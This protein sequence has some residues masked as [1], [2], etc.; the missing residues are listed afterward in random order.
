[1]SLPTPTTTFE[2]LNPALAE[3]SPYLPF[4]GEFPIRLDANE[5]PP[6]L[7]SAARERLAEVARTT[8]LERYPDATQDALRTVLAAR[9]GRSKTEILV[10]DGSDE[11]IALLLTAVNRS[12]RSGAPP[13]LLSTSPTF[14][15]YRLSAKIRG[16]QVIEVPL[17]ADWDLDER[18]FLRALETTSPTVVFVASPN[19][20]TSNLMDEARLVRLVEAARPALFVLDEA[21]VAYAPRDQARLLERH[22]NLVILRTLS[23]VGFAALRV[24]WLM[25]PS[26]LL[27]ELDK[28]RQPYNVPSLSQQL[29]TFA[30]TELSSELEEVTRTV[31]S[32]RGRLAHTLAGLPRV[33]VSPSDSNMLWLRTERPASEVFHELLA[34]GILVR[35]FAERGGR[36]RHQLRVTVGTPEENDAFLSALVQVT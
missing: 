3:L 20:P 11:L 32:E 1:V 33:E 12:R 9:T 34:R 27:A 23:K 30:L 10:G 15:M 24:G 14:V 16:F 25:G 26:W 36:L 6:L 28:A 13:V 7:S 29:A 22:S 8:P 18:A 5:A 17:D 19:N 4:A 2:L 31:I 35:S 21:Y